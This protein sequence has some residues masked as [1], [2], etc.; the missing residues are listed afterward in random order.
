MCIVFIVIVIAFP[1]DSHSYYSLSVWSARLA[2]RS[3]LGLGLD[4]APSVMPYHMPICAWDTSFWVIRGSY[5]VY[6]ASGPGM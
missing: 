1:S 2:T 3:R 5:H 4:F 6:A